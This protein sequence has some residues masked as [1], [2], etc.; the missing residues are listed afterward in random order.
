MKSVAHAAVF[1]LLAAF[2]ESV[3]AAD[4]PAPGM[5]AHYAVLTADWDG[6]PPFAAVDVV[7]GPRETV[8]G[9]E[10]QWWQLE[11]RKENDPKTTPLLS[12]RIL[13]LRD[14]LGDRPAAHAHRALHPQH[15]GRHRDSRISR[16]PRRRSACSPRGRISSST[17]FLA[18]AVRAGGSR[19]FPKPPLFSATHSRSSGLARM[20]P[21]RSLDEDQ[22]RGSGSRAAGRHRPE[23]PRFG[24]ASHSTDAQAAELHL[25]ATSRA[26]SIA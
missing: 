5:H 19:A 25:C 14:P 11:L 3:V 4:S 7:Y 21:G 26:M 20:S 22:A 10:C 24:G 12:L 13:S 18:R 9:Q 1:V 6:P 8:R 17:S 23:F 15:P 2:S 16:R